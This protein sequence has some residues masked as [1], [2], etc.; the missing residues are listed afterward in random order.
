[1]SQTTR[2]DLELV[3]RGLARSRGHARSLIDAGDV[4]VA[5][6]VAGKPSAPVTEA[7]VVDVREGGPQWVSRAAYKLVGAF[8]AFGP[9][10]GSTSG[11]PSGASPGGRPLVA[12]GK[13]CLDVGASTGGFTQVLLHHGAAHVVAL[14]VGHGQLVAEVAADPRVEDRPGT[15]I[16]GLTSQDIGGPVDLLVA[17]LSFISLTLVLPT[18]RALLRDDGDAVVLVKPQFE[19]GRTRLGKGG[20]VRS[21]GDRAWAITE[22]ARAAIEVGLHPWGLVASPIQGGEGNAE[23]L[24]WLTP[25]AGDGMGWEAL[26]RTADEVS[27][28]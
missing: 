12:T 21:Q 25:R 9:T 11:P 13:H 18:F 22:V 28:P 26:V 10:S 5:G 2:L 3:R 16:R 23:Y 17:D 19:V 6:V 24:L 8:E 7:D 4:T 20:I 1:M 15:T 27:A 14:D